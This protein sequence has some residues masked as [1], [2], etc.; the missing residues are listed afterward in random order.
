M[1]IVF[2]NYSYLVLYYFF[3]QFATFIPGPIVGVNAIPFMYCPF[4]A[5]GFA[6]TKASIITTKLPNELYRNYA[7]IQ[8]VDHH[9]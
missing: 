9:R 2:G 4:A 8:E 5:A 6:F 1:P 7:N 3:N